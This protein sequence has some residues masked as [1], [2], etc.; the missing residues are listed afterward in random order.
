M[1]EIFE[2]WIV[3]G[4]LIFVLIKPRI[5]LLHPHENFRSEIQIF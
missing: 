4:D 1:D 2:Q 5:R 3:R